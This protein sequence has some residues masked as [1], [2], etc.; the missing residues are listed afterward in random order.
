MSAT[1]QENDEVARLLTTALQHLG[2]ALTCLKE[3]DKEPVPPEEQDAKATLGRAGFK[4]MFQ[5]GS[6]R[7]VQP[8]DEAAPSTAEPQA[9]REHDEIH[10]LYEEVR[11]IYTRMAG[12]ASQR[13]LDPLDH[14]G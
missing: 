7:L 6:W 13:G 14:D 5:L 8:L 12:L 10:L 11:D 2:D 3:A 1:G 9:Q 4:Q